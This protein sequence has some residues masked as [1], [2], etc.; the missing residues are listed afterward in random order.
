MDALQRRGI[1]SAAVDLRGHGESAGKDEL[2]RFGIE[3]YVEDV[4]RALDAL[5]EKIV[6]AGHSMGGL[7]S[8][9]VAERKQ[10][11]GLALIASSPVNGMRNDGLRMFARHPFTFLGAMRRKSFAR[12]YRD[13][14][15]CRSL[16]FSPHTPDRVI[17]EF[18]S[19]VQEESWRA[20][21][22]MN[23][24]LPN[25]E[26]VKSPVLVVGGSED[27]MV[28]RRSIRR[29]ARAYD[30]I[31][32]FIPKAGHMIQLEPELENLTEILS[33]FIIEATRAAD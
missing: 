25:P 28:S 5:P 27:F 11:A 31:P 6:L 26:K 9:L 18:L 32:F 24:L 3:D 29:T 16:L 14:G 17:T 20:G 13:V 23:T 19:S 33:R 8:Q 1:Q 15:A 22:E 21:N 2:Q 10:T 4:T 30:S 7:V 12:L